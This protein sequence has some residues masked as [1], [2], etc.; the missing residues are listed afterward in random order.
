MQDKTLVQEKSL[1]FDGVELVLTAHRYVRMPAI[2]AMLLADWHIGKAA[3]FQ[4]YGIPLPSDYHFQE[5]HQL[6]LWIRQHQ[7]RHVIVLGDMFH[8]LANSDWEHFSF[9]RS[10]HPNVKISLVKGNHEKY[11]ASYY[12]RFDLAVVP[13][14][15]LMDMFLLTHEPN[16]RNKSLINLCG[17]IHPGYRISLK[18]RTSVSVACYVCDPHRLILPAFGQLTGLHPMKKTRNRQFF[19]IVEGHLIEF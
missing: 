4:Q 6:D 12:A 19:A 16:D 9:W 3:H 15:Q 7:I 17:H 18:A 5:L 8:A 1:V 11:A 10:K 13:Q 2:D 14:L